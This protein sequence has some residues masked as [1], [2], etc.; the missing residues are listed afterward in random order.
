[1]PAPGGPKSDGGLEPNG[2]VRPDGGARL[3]GGLAL[4]TVELEPPAVELQQCHEIIRFSEMVRNVLKY[5]GIE[6]KHTFLRRRKI[7]SLQ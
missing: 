1:V 6:I 7:L 2:G 3:V 5:H 4:G